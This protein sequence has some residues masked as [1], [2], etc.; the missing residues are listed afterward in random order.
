[1]PGM[2]LS[3]ALFV[4]LGL[5]SLPTLDQLA[6]PATQSKWIA[7]AR[8][9]S[10]GG[11]LYAFL[12]AG[13]YAVFLASKRRRQLPRFLL[14]LVGQHLLL[15]ASK[16]FF[17]TLRPALQH[18]VGGYAYPSGH[19]LM[20]ACLYGYLARQTSGNRRL[21]LRLLPWIVAWGRVALA[22]HWLRDVLGS[23]I[24]GPVWVELCLL[25]GETSKVENMAE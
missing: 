17:H 13:G 16:A 11:D 24:L 15:C 9:A 22:H 14:L 20:A 25:G 6:S 3:L 10:H 18:Q 23:L 2:L 4:Y 5:G 12:I 21:L 7:L 19:T 1:M 8:W